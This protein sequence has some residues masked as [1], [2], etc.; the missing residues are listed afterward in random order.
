MRRA[1]PLGSRRHRYPA[2]G[3]SGEWPITKLYSS[4]IARHR[5]RPRAAPVPSGAPRRARLPSKAPHPPAATREAGCFREPRRLPHRQGRG[6]R[7]GTLPGCRSVRTSRSGA[8]SPRRSRSWPT[9][10]APR[11]RASP[12]HGGTSGVGRAPSRSPSSSACSRSRG[13]SSSRHRRRSRAEGASTGAS[14]LSTERTPRAR[15]PASTSCCSSFDGPIDELAVR[16]AMR[17]LLAPI[18]ALTMALPPPDGPDATSGE[19]K[20]RA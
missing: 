17:E 13:S 1:S 11:T 18:E 2:S 12:T 16:R 6:V 19:G 14:A 7:C 5:P 8:R 15:S 4:R 3:P 9:A 10:R 20:R